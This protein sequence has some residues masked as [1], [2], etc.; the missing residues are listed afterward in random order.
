MEMLKETCPWCHKEVRVEA[1]RERLY[2]C[3]QCKK[4]F[5]FTPDP[6][7]AEDKPPDQPAAGSNRSSSRTSWRRPLSRTW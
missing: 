3:S 2:T 5:T 4:E 6:A 1:G 7:Q